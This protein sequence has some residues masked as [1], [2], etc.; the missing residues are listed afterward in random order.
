MLTGKKFTMRPTVNHLVT[1]QNGPWRLEVDPHTGGSVRGF[2]H[3][4]L[5]ILRP[6]P[7]NATHA[8][9]MAAFPLVPYSNRIGNQTFVWQGVHYTVRNGFDDGV[10]GLHGVGFMRPWQVLAKTDNSVEMRFEHPGD[11]YWPFAF[12]AEQKLTLHLHGLRV[13]LSLR[14]TDSCE[15]PAGL[16]WHPYFA[17]RDGAELHGADIHTQWLSDSTLLPTQAQARHGLHGPV[18]HLALDH[19]FSGGQRFGWCDA[20]LSVE[21]QASSAYWVVFTPADR[22]FFCIEPVS[23]VNNA[24]Q[25]TDPLTHGL[26]ALASGA[27]LT[28]TIDLLVTPSR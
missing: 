6:A 5:A 15:Q 2:W 20:E 3:A 22:D 1:L 25:M 13:Q 7:A 11:A 24:V 28:Q 27:S 26:V 10:H 21:L 12:V 9:Q 23:H 18:A 19:C 17:R 8:G 14:N 16:G 4:Q